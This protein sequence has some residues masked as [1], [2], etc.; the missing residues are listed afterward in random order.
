MFRNPE[1][2]SVFIKLLILQIIFS[3]CIF[4]VLNYGMKE[5]N[6]KIV[7]QNTA[8]VGNILNKH[9]ELEGEITG[10]ITKGP[11]KADIEKGEKLLIQYGYDK[12]MKPRLQPAFKDILPK[13]EGI[14]F[15]TSLIYFIPLFLLIRREYNFIYN[16][17]RNISFAA[18]R[19]VEG[20]FSIVLEEAG[21]GDFNILN[22]Q[23]NQMSNR[24]E[25][26]LEG[27][28]NEKSFLKNIISDISH[29]LKTPLSSLIMLNEL[30]LEDEDM[31]ED[32]K[33]DF[34]KRMRGQLDRMEWLII[35]L[36][37]MARLEV[38]AIQFKREEIF[39]REPIEIAISG[40]NT[41]IR[42]K[43]QRI[44]IVEK[45]GNCYFR[46]D[47]DW[48]GEAFINIIKNCV[49]HT[50]E[51]GEINIILSETPLFSQVV[52]RDNGEGIDRKDLPHVFKRFY[53]GS[54]DVK[55]DSIGIGLNLSK[56]IIESQDG[57]IS[58]KSK[59]GVGT[60]F[61]ITFLKGNI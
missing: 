35:N 17:V 28:N 30:I 18:E 59:K 55:A 33:V 36:L 8:I 61:T 49:E 58:V 11:S 47:K 3:I 6:K 5:V 23:F 7:E 54:S 13:V 44:N 12:S 46:G 16:K 26:S 42:E 10:Y 41:K 43:E 57:I 51:G 31:E 60:E 34:L 50:D 27:L 25:A 21:E 22:H 39:L 53:K 15:F 9:S 56:L 38:G 24:L 1:I 20:D 19:V 4:G 2:K 29:Q 48:T 32:I 37:K 40:L 14:I 45:N 52:I